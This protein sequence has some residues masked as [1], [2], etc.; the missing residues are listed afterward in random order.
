M[1]P[2][3]NGR[4][5]HILWAVIALWLIVTLASFFVP[6]VLSANN[7]RIINVALLS[8][9]TLLHGAQRYGIRGIVVYF[10]IAVLITNLTE[11]ISI[12]TGFPFGS[13]HHT[14]NMGPQIFHVPVIVGPIFAV[15]GYIAWT[16][17]GVLLRDVFENRWQGGTSR[18]ILAAFITTSW[19]LCVDAIGGTLNRDWIWADGGAWFGVPLMNFFGWMLTMWL[20]FQSFSFYLS[21]F[22]A[23]PYVIPVSSRYWDQVIV[24]W[25]LIALQFPLLAL[26]VPDAPLMD[27]GSGSWRVSD[28]LH[29][30]ALVSVFTMLFTAFLAAAVLSRVRWHPD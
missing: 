20:I 9:F 13:Y 29:S 10:S 17:S 21:R 18:S 4:A 30:M 22:A 23:R 3:D 19:D 25:T 8:C 26:I 28:L 12:V 6:Q 14:S 27:P 24:Y 11:N 5:H 2:G 7:A 16:L 1:P 15:A